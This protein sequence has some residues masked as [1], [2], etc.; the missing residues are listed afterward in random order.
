M[1]I[2]KFFLLMKL[3]SLAFQRE[4]YKHFKK[5]SAHYIACHLIAFLLRSIAPIAKLEF[6]ANIKA[7]GK[8]KLRNL[9]LQEI[10]LLH[11]YFH[12]DL[13]I[14]ALAILVVSSTKIL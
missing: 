4:T 9:C 7:E 6:V 1:L 13:P 12:F 10:Q 14:G 5:K 8:I 3:L 11:F 2:W